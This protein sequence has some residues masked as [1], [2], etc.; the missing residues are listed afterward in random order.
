MLVIPKHTATVFFES[1]SDDSGKIKLVCA[2]EDVN[3]YSETELLFFYDTQLKIVRGNFAQLYSLYVGL[4]STLHGKYTH[5]VLFALLPDKQEKNILI[6]VYSAEDL[7]FFLAI[8]I[9][10]VD[11]ESAVVSAI[12]AVFPDSVIT[13]SNFHF[14]QCLWRQLQNI[15]LMVEYK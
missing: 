11:F 9:M 12:N 3:I 5:P 15:S 6:F 8:G 7:V 1:I 14:I 10:K 2:G 4:G 13:G